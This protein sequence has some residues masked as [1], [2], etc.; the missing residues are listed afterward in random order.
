MKLTTQELREYIQNRIKIDPDTGCWMWQRGRTHGYGKAW[1]GQESR[2]VHRI[3]Y[4][5]FTEPIP[6]GMHLLHQCD[7][8][9]C[10]NPQHLLLGTQADNMH[11]MKRKG[12]QAKGERVKGSKLTG[13][14]VLEIRRALYSG[15]N[16]RDIARMFGVC[17]QTISRINM[18]KTWAHV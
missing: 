17:Q 1:D 5:A 3:S 7:T 2:Y 15:L 10:C 12:R 16:Q 8:P 11:D 4:E 18:R 14:L 13:A 6:R 9:L